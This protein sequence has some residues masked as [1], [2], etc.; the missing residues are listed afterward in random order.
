MTSRVRDFTTQQQQNE[1][2]MAMGK[3]S[4][5]LAHELNNPASAIVRGSASLL[6]HLKLVP[7]T[8]KKVISIK[9][10]DE[11]VDRVNNKMFAVL[12]WKD[13]PIRKY[14]YQLCS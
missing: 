14:G 7:D 10:S 9:M 2:M 1:K 6:K 12:A 4:A 11:Q 8:F 13:K 5:G 3:L